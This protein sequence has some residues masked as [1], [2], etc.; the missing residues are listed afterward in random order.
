MDVRIAACRQPN[1]VVRQVEEGSTD[2]SH[3]ITRWFYI[4]DL[5]ATAT[6]EQHALRDGRVILGV[7]ATDVDADAVA[8][9]DG[10]D[11]V[12]YTELSETERRRMEARIDEFRH[13][14]SARSDTPK[15]NGER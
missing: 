15:T 9:L 11:V 1:V 13:S 3:H 5:E 2:L 6:E 14:P 8:A 10:L 4:V 12:Y 7:S